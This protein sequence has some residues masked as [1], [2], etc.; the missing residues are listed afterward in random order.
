MSNVWITGSARTPIGRFLGELASFSAPELAGVAIRATMERSGA[1]PDEIDEVVLGNVLSSG[2]GQAPSKQAA[3]HAGLS[4][5][6]PCASVN[7][8]CGSGLFSVMLAS[9]AIRSGDANCVVAGGMES[10]S[11]APHLL[12][13]G[14]AG[15]KYGQQPLLDAI[16]YDGLRC[17]HGPSLMGVYAERVASMHAVDRSAQDAFALQSH[18]RAVE[19]MHLGFFKMEIAPVVDAKGVLIDRDG[20]PRADASIDRLGKLK[21][22]FLDNGTVTAGNASSL[23]DG[24]ASMI[25]FGDSHRDR[26]RGNDV[27]RLVGAAIHSQSPEDLFSAPI[28]AVRRLLETTKLTTAQVDLFEINEAFASQ[29]VHCMRELNIPSEKLNVHGG[30]IALG[31]PIGCSGARVLVT[32]MHSLLHRQESRG[33]AALCLGGGEAVAVMVERA[34]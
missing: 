10:M 34:A 25:V 28:G 9:R 3:L 5:A 6:T 23:S 15:W 24:A 22:A 4:P 30:A 27:F 11:N 20:S 1:G 16:E 26:F 21:C 8:V 7:K 31:H 14:R 19:A 18:Q 17:P 33:I 13:G 32:L 2:L 12:R 29:T